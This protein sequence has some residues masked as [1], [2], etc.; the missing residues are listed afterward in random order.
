MILCRF[1]SLIQ[2]PILLLGFALLSSGCSLV[3]DHKIQS[4][5]GVLYSDHPKE[6]TTPYIERMD[7]SARGI[8]SYIPKS[9]QDIS[10]VTVILS[11]EPADSGAVIRRG[12][13]GF[14]GWYNGVFDMIW[15]S[16]APDEDGKSILLELDSLD[17]FQHELAHHLTSG[18][19]GIQRRWWL[20]EGVACHF[21]GGFDPGDGSFSIPPFHIKYYE[22]CR[23]ELRRRGEARFVAD[24]QETLE[25]NYGTF[26]STDSELL[27]RYALSWGFLWH[28]LASF[29]EEDSFEDK[30][31]QI[32]A[33]PAKELL[34]MTQ[35]FVEDLS[36]RTRE[37]L[38]EYL[39]DPRLRRWAVSGLI[40]QYRASAQEIVDAL[41]EELK[42]NDDPTWTWSQFVQMIGSRS[43]RWP[44][45]LRNEWVLKFFDFMEN[46]T[47]AQKKQLCSEVVSSSRSFSIINA[48]VDC[49]ES[50]DADLRA[51]AAKSL[52]RISRQKTIVNPEFWMN[53]PDSLRQVEIDAWRD[54]LNR[55]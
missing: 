30:I 9:A 14:A 50:D 16:G 20:V 17:T 46:A 35:G 24:L 38:R 8:Q 23:Q 19:P 2:L 49:L 11:G 40:R 41:E 13:P 10:G 6:V 27:Y 42:Q 31:Y 32:A 53:A 52:A 21:E 12:R 18:I 43:L 4:N 28:L 22:K 15:L 34:L 55:D 7:W 25:G 45:G 26:Y 29:P 54:Y 3:Y 39:P 48:I 44:R 33:M 1:C 47:S 36:D 51:I 5:S 37:K